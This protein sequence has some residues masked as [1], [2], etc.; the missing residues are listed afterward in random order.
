MEGVF[1]NF[2]RLIEGYIICYPRA[3]MHDQEGGC[4]ALASSEIVIILGIY[5]G[6]YDNPDGHQL[7]SPRLTSAGKFGFS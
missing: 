3:W 1:T 4:L 7:F 2:M 5:V 6:I